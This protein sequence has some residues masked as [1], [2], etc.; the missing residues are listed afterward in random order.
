MFKPVPNQVDFVKQEHEILDFWERND[1]FEKLQEHLKGQKKFSFIDGPITAN[2]P[3]GVHHAW[4]R[5]YKDIFQRYK[6]LRGFDQRWQNGFDCQGLWVEVEVERDRGFQ[7]KKD[8]EAFGLAAFV[9]LCKQRVLEYAAVQTNQSIRLGY[10]MD[11]NDPA[12][13]RYLKAKMAEDPLQVIT[14]DGPN[15]PVTDTVEQI[16]GQLGLPQLG[17]SYFTFS[18]ENNYTIWTALKK[19]HQNG[20]IYKGTDVMPWCARC[21][22]GIS[23]HEIV[24]EGYRELTHP[25][26]FVRFPLRER[27][28]EDL[29]VWTTTPWTLT[30]NVAAAVH[31]DLPYVLVEQDGRAPGSQVRRF[32]LSRGALDNAM[33]GRYTVVDEKPGAALEGWTYD[34]PFDELPAQQKSGSVAAHRVILW[35]EVSEAEGTGIVHIAPG[36]GA[37]DYELGQELGLPAIAPLNEG[38]IY[39]EGFAWLTGMH[40]HDTAQPIFENLERKGLLYRLQDYTHRYPVCWRCQEELVF[41]LVDEWFIGMGELLDKPY[42][43]VTAKEKASRLRYQIMDSMQETRWIPAFGYEREMDWLRN[44]HDWMISKKRYYGLTLPIWECKECGWFDVVGSREELKARA[45]A[46]WQEFE[47]HPPHRPYVDAV[48]IRCESCGAEVSRIPEVGS[49][50]LDAGIVAYS[51]LGYRTD[52]EYWHQWFPADLITESFPGQFRN[53]FYSMLAMSTI[54]ERR[55]PFRAVQTYALLLGEDGREMHKSWGNSI[56]FNEAADTMGVDVM[57]WMYCAHKPETNLLFGYHRADE[58][59][60]RFLIPLWNV[61]SFFVTYANLDEWEPG[62]DF[63]EAL[64]SLDRWILA[65]LNQVIARVTECMEDYDP[66]GATLVLEP[67]LDDL[68]NWYVRRSR[69]RFWKSQ[70]DADKNAAYSTLYQVL[71]MLSKLLAPLLPFVTEAMYQNLARTVNQD[72]CESVHHCEWPEANMDAVDQDLLDRMALAMQIAALG[73]S[74]R[75][76]SNVKLRQPLA[77]ARVYAG[78]RAT[79]LGDLAELVTDELN[80]KALEFVEQEADLVEYEIG[81]LPNILGPKHGKRFPLVRQ[82]IAAMGTEGAAALA[83]RFQAGLGVTVEMGDGGPAV[84]L[85]PEEVEVRIHGREGYAVAEEKGIVVAVDVTLTPELARE[86]LARDLVRRVQALRKEAGFQIDDRIVTYWDGDEEL[87]AIVDEWRDYIQAE[88]LSQ[89]LVSGPVPAKVDQQVSLKLGGHPLT[90]GVKRIQ[91]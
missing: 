39:V 85:L 19:C 42:E 55:A 44:M 46:G 47:D 73:R 40:V 69:R 91:P 22:T 57:R 2:N 25:S 20:W 86:G 53:W 36:C 58:T 6:A 74:A 90:L 66:Y 14:L 68:T 77:R 21:G 37:E 61:Y 23:Q 11:W 34:G 24:T 75:S 16:V 76:T 83:R 71:L 12:H 79:D 1:A 29:L 5:T 31:P 70:R 18:N 87:S 32:W 35:D 81:L 65:R 72:V 64:P 28:G 45:I 38:G 89:A 3:M 4:G 59:R 49:P 48:K 50:W 13:L 63:P 9:N 33:R 88:T 62:E 41:R 84:E 7:S 27:P 56:E 82:A 51:T 26:I 43:Q 67:L 60:R 52:P 78:D 8:I 15:G 80:L 10:W 30:S 54:M 17:G